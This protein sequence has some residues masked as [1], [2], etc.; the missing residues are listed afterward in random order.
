MSISTTQA[1]LGVTAAFTV[2]LAAGATFAVLFVRDE[3]KA[4]RK[5]RA[6]IN[7]W[8]RDT[9]TDLFDRFAD[10]EP[11]PPAEVIVPE[12]HDVYLPEDQA[13]PM[14]MPPGL[15]VALTAA[16]LIEALT[17]RHKRAG[18]HA[19]VNNAAGHELLLTLLTPTQQL[20][21][22]GSEVA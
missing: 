20:R 13:V 16:F 1:V 9:T 18:K 3:L 19:G 12:T 17:W 10:S 7:Q 15:A 21:V 2:G 8:D 22:I 14:V 11:E 6:Y 4:L 5:E